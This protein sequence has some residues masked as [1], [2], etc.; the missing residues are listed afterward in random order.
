[1]SKRKCN[2]GHRLRQL[3]ISHQQFKQ[4][5]SDRLMVFDDQ[6]YNQQQAYVFYSR[7]LLS[8]AQE[9]EEPNLWM[10]GALVLERRLRQESENL[11]QQLQAIRQFVKRH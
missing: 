8:L 11:T 9:E 5:L 3:K 4:S 2:A 7:S 1:M 6:L 10:I